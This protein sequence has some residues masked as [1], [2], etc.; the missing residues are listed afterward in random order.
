MED[1]KDDIQRYR[2]GTLSGPE[3]NAL[4]KKA[5]TDP[6]LAD[7]LE[8][9]D[10]IPAEQFSAD[11]ASLS[12]K[13]RKENDVT[14]FTPLRIAAGIVLLIGVGALFLLINEPDAKLLASEEIAKADSAVVAKDSTSS[15]LLAL[16]KADKA[17]LDEAV[18]KQAAKA[19]QQL[20][21][22]P[23]SESKAKSEINRDKTLA[24]ADA[25]KSE[26]VT[27]QP[28]ASE[29]V[30]SA[31]R[32]AEE[33]TKDRIAEVEVL[34]EDLKEEAPQAKK[35]IVSGAG[36]QLKRD[37]D[38]AR[39][40][41]S[42]GEDRAISSGF[43]LQNITG[44]VTSTD[45]G[46]PLPGVNVV[47]KGTNQGTVTDANGNYSMPSQGPGTVL[48]FSFIGMKTVDAKVSD[49]LKNDVVMT[50]DATQLSE[51]VVTGLG[52]QN[53]MQDGVPEPV[54]K[55]A[56]PKGGLRAYNKYLE[57]NLRYTAEAIEN[58]VKGKVTIGF[59]VTT[60]GDLT[61][62]N[63]VKGLGH[64]C[65]EEVIRLVK[66]G[67]TWSPSTRDDVAVESEVKV[68]VKFDSEKAKK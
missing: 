27:L 9:A 17:A 47:I 18:S 68:R 19:D 39:S 15:A 29:S 3:R 6:F 50:P 20:A 13:I 37:D 38:L 62:F 67:P 28:S 31:G 16:E 53:T 8:G 41:A 7:A 26:K 40:R 54:V 61:D 33:D 42:R 66:E 22:A 10:S 59:T 23:T 1:K 21:I 65:D 56:L 63:V 14:V 64:G 44:Q 11:I 2:E 60:A 34:E 49:N 45:D 4:E 5:L 24:N 35:S 57:K 30:T 12:G 48:E 25:T 43:A 36:A 52:L 58:K 46:S 32:E 55:L 51:V